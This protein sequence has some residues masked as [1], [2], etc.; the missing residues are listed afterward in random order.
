MSAVKNYRTGEISPEQFVA[1]HTVCHITKGIMLLYDGNKTY[2]FRAGES[3]LVRKNHLLRFMKEK[4]NDELEKV[5]IFLDEPFLKRY[6]ERYQ[7][8]PALFRSGETVLELPVNSLVAH[9]ARSLQPYYKNGEIAAPFRDLKR[10]E[11][12][13]ILLQKQPELAGIF[14][15]Y[16][17]PLKINLEEFM[18]RNYKFNV[19]M[20]RLAFLCGRS[21]SAFKRDFRQTFGEAPNHWLVRRRQ[22]EGHFLIEKKNKKASDIYL[23]LG[24][25]TLSHFSVAFKRQF[26]Y[27]PAHISKAGSAKA[28]AASTRQG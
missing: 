25:E 24:F 5:F 15:N 4:V 10:E 16:G 13:L 28:G 23:E 22:K 20:E 8:A 3:F 6:Q 17:T 2:T 9:F 26:G 14:F 21:L 19:R 7:P 18:E 27:P 11:L 1:E 12:L